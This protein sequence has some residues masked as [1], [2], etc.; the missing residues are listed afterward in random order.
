MEQAPFYSEIAEGPIGGQTFWVNTDDKIRL[1]VGLWQSKK[2][3]QG[4][5]FFLPGRT[6]Y[7]ER[8]GR[9]ATKLSKIGLASFVIDWRGLGLSDRL[10]NDQ[11][12]C[13]VGQYADYQHDV[14]AMLEA[15]KN[16]DLPKPW[17]LIGN[18]MGACIG[19]RAMAEGLKVTACA[20]IAPMWGINL[21][22]VQ[23][24]AATAISWAAQAIGKESAYAP[25]YNGQNYVVKTAFADNTMTNDEN[26]YRYWT[27][28]A[29]AQPDLLIGGPT[30]GWLFQSLKE[31]KSL[32]TLRSPNIP[33]I[34]FRGDDDVDV[35][36][37]AIKDRMANWPN[38]R[39]EQI[40]N[41]KHDVLNEIPEIREDVLSKI[42]D[43]FT[44]Q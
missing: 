14:N 15:A 36:I 38:G 43:L 9:I 4:T 16:L 44:A 13:H 18:S 26:M 22:P 2:T 39:F 19:L 6:G 23:Y 1:R 20:F 37:Q 24:H 40:P 25:G 12:A 42:L 27:Q 30:M 8:Y 10:V 41:A 7:I 11:S 32:S 29:H 28:Q 31:C 5:V 33:C 3:K 17:Y 34:V 35:D 21:S